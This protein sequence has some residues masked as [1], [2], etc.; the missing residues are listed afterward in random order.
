MKS[1]YK[2][3]IYYHLTFLLR[4]IDLSNKILTYIA[5]I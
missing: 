4:K 5:N 1:N 3:K 2:S